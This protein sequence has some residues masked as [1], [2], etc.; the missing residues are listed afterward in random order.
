M[1]EVLVAALI[2]GTGLAAMVSSWYFSFNMTG[3][4]TD[5]S[6]AYSL[7][8]QTL[9][10]VKETGFSN[11]AEIPSSSPQVNYYDA[12]GNNQN[13]N[14]SA[15]R[16]KTTLTVVSSQLNGN[17]PAPTAIRTVSIVVAST[18]NGKTICQI[19][20]YLVQAGI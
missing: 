2:V 7:A 16:Y 13:S 11:T 9:E 17:V 19:N 1:I 3:Q 20:T 10:N 12:L 6:V 5:K 8:R 15:A 18:L 14:T 4:S